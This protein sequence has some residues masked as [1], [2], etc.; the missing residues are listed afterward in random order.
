MSRGLTVGS[1]VASRVWHT[2]ITLEKGQSGPI[3]LRHAPFLATG[4]LGDIKFPLSSILYPSGMRAFL[5]GSVGCEAKRFQLSSDRA[6]DGGDFA[7]LDEIKSGI[8]DFRSMGPLRQSQLLACLNCLTEQRAALPCISALPESYFA[9]ADGCHVVFEAARALL[10]MGAPSCQA[11]RAFG[12]LSSDCRNPL[13]GALSAIQLGAAY[14]RLEKDAVGASRSIVVADRWRLLL[15]EAESAFIVAIVDSR[16]FRL[17]AL[18]AFTD[19]KSECAKSALS[20]ALEAAVVA[21]ECAKETYERLVAAENMRLV[22]EVNLKAA[23]LAFNIAAFES[24]A[25]RLLEG[26]GEDSHSWKCISEY[27]SRCGLAVVAALGIAGLATVCGVGIWP[28][29]AC[30]KPSIGTARATVLEEVMVDRL[31]QFHQEER[32]LSVVRNGSMVTDIEAAEG[33]KGDGS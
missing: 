1:G 10:R 31:R 16:Y 27:A 11:K 25:L 18:A 12:R 14:L 33:F 3:A 32:G 4:E 29:L 22:Y 8:R 26:D 5:L 2:L 19:G 21:T 7:A 24:W 23:S 9:D 30:L 20:S 13:V 28:A 15:R 17:V 6:V